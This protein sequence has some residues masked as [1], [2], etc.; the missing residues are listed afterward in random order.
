MGLFGE[1]NVLALAS[2]PT[3]NPE[4]YAT[5]L[6]F[7]ALSDDP[8][9]LVFVSHPSTNHGKHL[10]AGP[11]K[12]AGCIFGEHTQV[13]QLRGVQFRGRTIREDVLPPEVVARA[14]EAYL[15]RHPVAAPVL[16]QSKASVYIMAI[17]W[18][19]LTDNR[20]AFGH[21]EIFEFESPA[22][23]PAT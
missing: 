22:W 5:P 21:K 8:L 20:V 9:L 12:V 3:A 14:R 17:R 2:A 6:Y 1:R 11:T 15:L 7:A 13:A 4:P 23:M 10:G 16:E 19:K 18:A